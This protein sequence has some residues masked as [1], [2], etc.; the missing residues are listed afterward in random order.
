[1]YRDPVV[2]RD[3]PQYSVSQLGNLAPESEAVVFLRFPLD[4]VLDDPDA[5]LFLQV[6]TL[7]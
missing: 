1:M 4:R 5:P 7:S 3:D 2:E 6:W